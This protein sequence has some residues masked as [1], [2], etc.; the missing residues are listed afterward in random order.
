LLKV[1]S[2]LIQ[3]YTDLNLAEIVTR[4][5][6]LRPGVLSKTLDLKKPIYKKTASGGHFGR[7]DADFTWEKIID[8][9]HEKIEKK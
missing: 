5:F 4:N 9:K 8:L 7:T 6:D 2:L 3:G 1:N